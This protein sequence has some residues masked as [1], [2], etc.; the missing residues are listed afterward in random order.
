VPRSRMRACS[1]TFARMLRLA[2]KPSYQLSAWLSLSHLAAAL[3]VLMVPMPLWLRTVLALALLSNLIYALGDQAWRR[4][5][6]SIVGLQFERDGLVIVQSRN[7]TVVEARVLGSSF[8]APYLTIVFLKRE[9][10]W[11]SSAVVILP[12]AIE[13]DLFRQLRVWLKWGIGRGVEP[14]ETVAWA[15]RL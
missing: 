9:R 6:S 12:D 15:G 2:L 14:E 4:W 10:R 3:C 5:P 13:P 11:L 7:G 1:R 8:V